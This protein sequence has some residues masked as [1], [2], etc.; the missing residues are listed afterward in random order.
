MG[1]GRQA[2]PAVRPASRAP[3]SAPCRPCP[4]RPVSHRRSRRG[5]ALAFA[6]DPRFDDFVAVDER[7]AR[8]ADPGLVE[9]PQPSAIP[10]LFSRTPVSNMGKPTTFEWLPDRKR[11]KGF[12]AALDRIAARLA[13][14]LA[15]SRRYQSVSAALS[16]L[17]ATTVSTTRTRCLAVDPDD[18]DA[19]PEHGAGARRGGRA[20]GAGQ[21]RPPAFRECADRPRRSSSPASDDFV[22]RT[23]DRERLAPCEARDI[24]ARQLAFQRGFV[25]IGRCDTHRNHPD[26]RQQSAPARRRGAS[27]SA[28]MIAAPLT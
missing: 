16:I 11:S 13:H 9:P 7:R 3:T 25:D 22:R 18:S 1:S 28:G 5:A 20:C 17:K 4:L 6:F 24:V 12:G 8:F 10:A 19:R 21:P 15:R 14:A 23:L 26:P 2:P 27:T